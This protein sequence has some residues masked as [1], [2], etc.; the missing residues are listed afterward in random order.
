[1][2]AMADRIEVET[3]IRTLRHLLETEAPEKDLQSWFEG[4]PV[5]FDA[6]GFTR[7]LA[8]PRL[9][10]ENGET[11]VP[12]F[13]V[14]DLS[15]QWHVL[16]LKRPD[17]A[18]LK[19]RDRRVTFYAPFESYV[20]Q[21]REYCDYFVQDEQ[22]ARFNAENSCGVQAKVA[23]IVVAGRRDDFDFVK[24][25]NLLA[26]R[27][28]RVA[29]CTFDDVATRLEFLRAQLYAANEHRPG[30]SIHMLVQLEKLAGRQNYLWNAGID[31]GSNH[32]SF[33]VDEA[34][35]MVLRVADQDGRVHLVSA[36]LE[37]AGVLY[38]VPAYVALELGFAKTYTYVAFEVNGHHYEDRRL[39][40]MS[41]DSTKLRWIA[42]GANLAADTF[43]K[44]RFYEMVI[45][46][47]TLP[48]G[49]RDKLAR[50]FVNDAGRNGFLDL[51]SRSWMYTNRLLK[52][53]RPIAGRAL[54]R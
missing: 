40:Q 26:D 42:L 20:S 15:G 36:P 39:D 47:K 28:R 1:M 30:F 27:G 34:D 41:F 10:S 53:G 24:A 23:A 8:H 16:E 38:G 17:T 49:E 7:Y 6:F 21:C 13:L 19:D 29:L 31:E 35:Q 45:A 12:D 14:E 44:F 48:F 25:A 54:H 32:V 51:D 9:V 3:A 46:D 52:F 33:F 2:R 11:L 43:G 37:R 18:V 5:V 22:R 4:N 50:Y